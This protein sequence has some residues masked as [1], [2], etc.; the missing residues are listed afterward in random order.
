M[1]RVKRFFHYHY[2]RSEEEI[3]VVAH[4][5]ILKH[6]LL[7]TPWHQPVPNACCFSFTIKWEATSLK[8]QKK[9]MKEIE[10]E[11]AWRK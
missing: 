5:D 9:N 7:P 6:F 3:I 2:T 1:G 4:E 8:A 10:L 11:R